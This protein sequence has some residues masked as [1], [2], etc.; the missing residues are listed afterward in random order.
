[1]T[2]TA[3][4]QT[5]GS[6][7]VEPSTLQ[8]AD[9][10]DDLSGAIA[11]DVPSSGDITE[12]KEHDV[13]VAEAERRFRRLIENAHDLVYRHRIH[14]T[15][16][17]EYVG[18]A[19]K[20]ITGRTPADFYADPD[21]PA[22][23]V[24]PDDAHLV[25][26]TLRDPA[27]LKRADTLRWIHPDGRIVWAEHRRVPVY[28]ASGTLVAIEGIAR[29]VTDRVETQQ[30]LR[31][32]QEQMRQ[33]AARIQSAREE[34]RTT[35]AR[36]LHDELG[37]TLTAIKLDLGRATGAMRDAGVGSTVVDRLQS[38]IGLVEIGIETV[39]R[40]TTSL[41]PPTLD[42]LG[43][44]EAIRWEAM[45]FRSR[46]GLRCHVRAD[47]E[48]TALNPEQQTALFRIF[49]EALT[50]VV[51]HARASAVNVTLAERRG[52]FDLRIRDNGCGVTDEQ[53]ADPHAIGLLGM[54]ERAAFIGGTFHIAGRRGKGTAIIVRVPLTVKRKRAP[55]RRRR[56][57][58]RRQLE[59]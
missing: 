39:K 24:H 58:A 9:D 52:V 21:L 19:V 38:L 1:M 54:R 30:R 6:R 4:H 8:N 47:K 59:R 18:G 2:R 5:A 36:E 35:L 15:R 40:I 48:S 26:E 50:N 7:T 34:E 29:D 22:K 20:Q 23:A 31:E 45:T 43:L 56:T 13:A 37:Q 51:R 49:Q 11:A 33:L 44:P 46:T 10:A 3:E 55:A 12:H 17:I 42:Y 27:H 32:S 28:D 41:R 53:I 14:P 25:I 57:A 16:A